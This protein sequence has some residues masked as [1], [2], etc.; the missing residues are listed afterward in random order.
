M[1]AIAQET[2]RPV[3]DW[4]RANPAVRL[5]ALLVVI[6]LGCAEPPTTVSG[7]VTLDGKPLTLLDGMRGTVVFQP[8]HAGPVLN[9][10]IR[11]DGTF[12]M[13]AGSNDVVEPGAYQVLV[14]AV[15]IVA[16]TEDNPMPSSTRIT[17]DRFSSAVESDLRVKI[18]PGPNDIDLSLTSEADLG[19][20]VE[21]SPR[22][23]SK[24]ADGANN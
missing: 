4:L 5:L 10:D 24:H 22:D 3:S 18:V 13:S 20:G 8:E 1:T 19:A 21:A 15:E 17:P 14:S 16:P 23:N 2:R 12:H 6:A 7:S 11:P 9:G